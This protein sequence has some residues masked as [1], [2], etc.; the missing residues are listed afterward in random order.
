VYSLLKASFFDNAAPRPFHIGLPLGRI[1]HRKDL[2]G[3]IH[4]H[5][6]PVEN[7][8]RVRIQRVRRRFLINFRFRTISSTCICA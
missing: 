8:L 5:L 6:I 4:H 7:E 3:F 1:Q 2:R